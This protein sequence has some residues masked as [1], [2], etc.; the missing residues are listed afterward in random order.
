MLHGY[1]PIIRRFIAGLMS[2]DEFERH[3]TSYFRYQ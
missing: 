3:Y 2:G 1:E